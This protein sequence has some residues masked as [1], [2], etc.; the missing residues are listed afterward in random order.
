MGL[1]GAMTHDF[2][3][4]QA[5]TGTP[6]TRDMVLLYSEIDPALHAAVAGGTYGTAAYSSTITYAPRY[7][8]VNG[9][10][11]SATSSIPTFAGQFGDTILLRFLNAGLQTRVPSFEG[12]TMSILAEDGHRYAYPKSGYSVLLPAGK[13]IDATLVPGAPGRMPC[14]TGGSPS[15]TAQTLRRDARA[16]SDRDVAQ[17]GV[18]RRGAWYPRRQFERKM[19]LR[20]RR[21]HGLLSAA[22]RTSR[23]PGTGTGTGRP[24][25]ASSGAAPG[26]RRQ[27]QT[28]SGT[29]QC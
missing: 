4:R 9:A 2:A 21:L 11:Y 20:I 18:F 17:I 22:P 13:T 3:T 29:A 16:P 14:S 23:S 1:Y 26:P 6:Y 25:S 15:R 28:A 24:R 7:F 19:G 8:L 5:Y 10:P 27:R 12:V